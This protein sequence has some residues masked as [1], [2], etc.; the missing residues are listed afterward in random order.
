MLSKKIR[1]TNH[2]PSEKNVCSTESLYQLRCLKGSRFIVFHF[3]D[4]S[5]S[6]C[7]VIACHEQTLGQLVNAAQ[8]PREDSESVY[9]FK[10]TEIVTKR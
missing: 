5:T 1:Q 10:M 7:C 6:H 8:P 2:T 4:A 3:S 9:F